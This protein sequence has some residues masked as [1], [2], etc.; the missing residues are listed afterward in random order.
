MLFHALL[1][2][3]AVM[4]CHCIDADSHF[5]H[6][7]KQQPLYSAVGRITVHFSSMLP[8]REKGQSPA[9]LKHLVGFCS[10]LRRNWLD[11]VSPSQSPCLTPAPK[12]MILC[13]HSPNESECPE[14]ADL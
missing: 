14:Q 1:F 4:T 2:H 6:A 11:N 13:G 5:S 7:H 3:I 9:R 8:L 12:P 10:L